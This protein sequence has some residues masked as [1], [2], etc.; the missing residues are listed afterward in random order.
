M[1]EGCLIAWEETRWRRSYVLHNVKEA[2]SAGLKVGRVVLGL[3]K[4]AVEAAA[5]A[6]GQGVEEVGLGPMKGALETRA[7][8]AVAGQEEEVVLDLITV[9]A[10][11]GQGV[12]EVFLGVIRVET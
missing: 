2:G 7:V 5:A 4:A 8:A 11:S 6:A 10:G 1:G 3:M 9:A 12:G